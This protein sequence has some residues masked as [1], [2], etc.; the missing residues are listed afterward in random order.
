M[1]AVQVKRG[2]FYMAIKDLDLI[3]TEFKVHKHFFTPI[4]FRIQKRRSH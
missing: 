3:A 4:H 2:N 1:A